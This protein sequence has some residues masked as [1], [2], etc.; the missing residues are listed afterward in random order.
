MTQLEFLQSMKH[1][2][3]RNYGGIPGLTSWLIG[4]PSPE[5]LVRLME[6]SRDHQEPIVPH[7]HRFDFHC[8]VLAGQVR[9]L[10]WTQQPVHGDEFQLSELIYGGKI[11]KYR[12]NAGFIERWS[13]SS[14]TY[15]EGGEYSMKAD[16]VHSIFFSRGAA[17]LFFEGPTISETSIILEPFVDGEV[18]PTFK[19]ESW[20]FKRDEVRS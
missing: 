4:A 18:V 9:N 5:G 16:E 12:C 10:I 6:C 3:V 11:G 1:S 14:S 17:V 7:S 2:P 8:H 13:I 15:R 19:V 20:M